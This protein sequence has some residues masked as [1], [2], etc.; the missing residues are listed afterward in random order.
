MDFPPFT[1]TPADSG[2]GYTDWQLSYR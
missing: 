2:L 1:L